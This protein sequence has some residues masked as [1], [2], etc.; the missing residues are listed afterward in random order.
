MPHSKNSQSTIR[1]ITCSKI[2]HDIKNMESLTPNMIQIIAKMPHEE[3]M[4]V[5]LAY[6]EMMGWMREFMAERLEKCCPSL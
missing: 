2:I 1:D 3:K 5:I 4:R 6:D